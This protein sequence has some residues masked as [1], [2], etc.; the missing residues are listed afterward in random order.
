M[1]VLIKI[2]PFYLSLNLFPLRICYSVLFI[3]LM[4]ICENSS[5]SSLLML[6]VFDYFWLNKCDS[7]LSYRDL[8]LFFLDGLDSS[9]IIEDF[10]FC[11]K[12]RVDFCLEHASNND[13]DWGFDVFA[14]Q[15]IL[16][17]YLLFY[18]SG[19]LLTLLVLLRE[20]IGLLVFWE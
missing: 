10:C 5:Y 12:R 9:L 1:S 17:S 3:S 16:R 18:W 6:L 4:K 7:L 11:D 20:E 19:R 8:W 15:F 2:Y 14:L 13:L